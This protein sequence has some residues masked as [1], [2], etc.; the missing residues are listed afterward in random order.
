MITAKTDDPR[1]IEG[2]S[3]MDDD[4]T[5]EEWF[6]AMGPSPEMTREEWVASLD[7]KPTKHNIQP[8]S[9]PE[10]APDYTVEGTVEYTVV[11]IPDSRASTIALAETVKHLVNAREISRGIVELNTNAGIAI[12]TQLCAQHIAYDVMV[13]DNDDPENRSSDEAVRALHTAA[14]QHVHVSAEELHE[15]DANYI[16]IPAVSGAGQRRIDLAVERDGSVDIGETTLPGHV[17]K[18]LELKA[19]ATGVTE[20]L[21]YIDV[22][23]RGLVQEADGTYQRRV[24]HLGLDNTEAETTQ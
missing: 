20:E 11:F 6:E 12:A 21:L 5:D 23:E 3:D 22:P 19:Q 9:F 18:G 14:A 13:F 4:M 2:V 16:V 7:E 15:L 1:Y 17:I 10:D 24:L 8:S